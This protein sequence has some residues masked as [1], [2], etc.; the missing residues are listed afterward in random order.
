[1]MYSVVEYREDEQ[2]FII[3]ECSRNYDDLFIFP[4]HDFN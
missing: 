3:L 2:F 1:M 4:M